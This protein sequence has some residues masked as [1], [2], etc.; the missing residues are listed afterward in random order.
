M[1][2]TIKMLAA[3]TMACSATLSGCGGSDTKVTNK[4]PVTDA[5]KAQPNQ[6]DYQA[7]LNETVNSEVPGV[8]L[9]I[10]SPTVNFYGAAGIADKETNTP[11]QIDAVLPNGSAGKKLTAMLAVMLHE[12]GRLDLDAPISDYL[13]DELLSRIKH[14]EQMTTRQLLAHTSGVAG[15]LSDNDGD[16]YAGVL[17]TPNT[18]IT[19]SFALQYALDKPAHFKPGEGWKYSNTGYILTGLIL[20]SVLGEHHSKATRDYVL[21]PL[22]L[23]SMSYIGREQ[24]TAEFASGYFLMDGELVNTRSYY[25]YIGVADAPVAGSAKDMAELLR[26]IVEGDGVSEQVREHLIGKVNLVAMQ[27]PNKRY[28]MGV[29][30]EKTANQTV[31]YHGGDELGYATRDYYFPKSKTAITMLFNCNMYE[32]CK[33]DLNKMLDKVLAQFL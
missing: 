16:F 9:Y 15:Y 31:Y 23:T 19:D 2:T 33:K 13:P 29:I 11:M 8:V 7:L 14:S 12:E 6:F 5:V 26:M 4:E 21:D 28:G 30:V 24:S 18:L 27:Q 22:G 3:A 25:Q 1:K 17:Q 32:L 20:D 10:S